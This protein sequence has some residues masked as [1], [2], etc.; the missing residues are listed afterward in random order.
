MD[1]LQRVIDWSLIGSLIIL[2]ALSV[3]WFLLDD[4][5]AFMSLVRITSTCWVIIVVTW[6][7]LEVVRGVRK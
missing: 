6:F 3:A 4:M 2:A 1:K 7:G 5:K